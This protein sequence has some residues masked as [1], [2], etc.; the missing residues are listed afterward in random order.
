MEKKP[1]MGEGRVL[2]MDDEKHVRDTAASMLSSIG[3]EV[4]TAI[5][6]AEAIEIYKEAMSSDSPFD[7]IVMDLTI[8]GGMGGKETIQ[9][10]MEIDP[11]VK[12][13]VSS[14]YS[15]DPVLANFREYGFMGFI[16]KPYKIQE[17]SEILHG[18]IT[19][20]D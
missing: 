8:P 9:R 13:I 1:I 5:D 4:I 15:N 19:G 10:L 17:L 11:E 3:Y 20:T 18:V 16:P 12:A 7:A 6:G 2:V 14:G